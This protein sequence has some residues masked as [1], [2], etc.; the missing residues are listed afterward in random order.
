[1]ALVPNRT[2]AMVRRATG[3]ALV[4]DVAASLIIGFLTY[5]LIGLIVF[6]IGLLLIGAFYFNMRQVMKTRGL[7]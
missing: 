7:R 6:I 4:S 1:M 2:G 3:W 5:S